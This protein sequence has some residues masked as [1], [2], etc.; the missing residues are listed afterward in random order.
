[1]LVDALYK[2]CQGCSLSLVVHLR[3]GACARVL[4]RGSA[5]SLSSSL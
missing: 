1:M 3:S 4:C 2:I 5:Y